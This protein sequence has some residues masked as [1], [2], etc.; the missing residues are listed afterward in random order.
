ML[1][2]LGCATFY[3]KTYN[4][5][6][7][8]WNEIKT[9]VGTEDLFSIRMSH[10]QCSMF[11]VQPN[12]YTYSGWTLNNNKMP[13]NYWNILSIFHTLLFATLPIGLCERQITD[14]INR[15]TRVHFHW[16]YYALWECWHAEKLNVQTKPLMM[17]NEH[18]VL[19]TVIVHGTSYIV[20]HY[21]FQNFKGLNFPE[22]NVIVNYVKKN[23]LFH[24]IS[25]R[26]WSTY[27]P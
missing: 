16:S 1:N 22:Q 7:L 20:H 19:G 3:I 5:V 26:H 11:R 18:D 4:D 2:M 6:W 12:G 24:W 17:L 23:V 15:S 27:Q 13:V 14:A 10:V 9:V 25:F 8:N 21:Q